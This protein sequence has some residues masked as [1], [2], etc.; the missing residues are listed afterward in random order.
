MHL[1]MNN[2]TQIKLSDITKINQNQRSKKSPGSTGALSKHT[3]L[4]KT[5][6]LITVVIV[7]MMGITISNITS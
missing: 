7:M 2:P 4:N 6:S 1:S 5:V 3:N